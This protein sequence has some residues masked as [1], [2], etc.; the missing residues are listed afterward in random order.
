MLKRN[1]VN[2]KDNKQNYIYC[3]YLKYY[4]KTKVLKYIEKKITV[5]TTVL[6]II[7]DVIKKNLSIL[8]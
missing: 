5:Y 2:S 3:I 8:S 7:I 1:K 4:F 6:S